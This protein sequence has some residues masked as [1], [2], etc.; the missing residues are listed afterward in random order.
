MIIATIINYSDIRRLEGHDARIDRRV[1]MNFR[2]I[3]NPNSSDP[4]IRLGGG[5]VFHRDYFH[6]YR[7]ILVLSAIHRRLSECL[8]IREEIFLFQTE[9]PLYKRYT[10][11]SM[12]SCTRAELLSGRFIP[13]FALIGSNQPRFTSTLSRYVACSYSK[14]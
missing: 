3:N 4:S 14:A 6:G 9:L 2:E 7:I 11:D 8:A 13:T 12:L 5:E 1:V 10:D